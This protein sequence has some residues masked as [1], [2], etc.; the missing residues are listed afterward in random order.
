[1]ILG[2]LPRIARGQGWI[3]LHI[4]QGEHRKPM[5]TD[6]NEYSS[7]RMEEFVIEVLHP[8]EDNS[9]SDS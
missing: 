3:K 5:E 4:E 8:M 1:M 6:T 2:R 7:D 9:R